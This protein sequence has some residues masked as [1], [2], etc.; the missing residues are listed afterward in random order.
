M[1]LQLHTLRP[2]KG[3]RKGKKRVGRG[4]GSKGT[5]SGRGGKGQTARSGVS[6][7]KRL[8]MRHIILATPKVRGFRSLTPKPSVVNFTKLAQ[9]FQEGAMVTPKVLKEKGLVPANAVNVKILA[10]G[11]LGKALTV[12][13]CS[14]SAS[15]REKIQAAGGQVV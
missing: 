15:A 3:A 12:K 4:L 9:V 13:G 6:G 8:G 11:A 10:T 2:A 5:Y 7:T 1:A 14:V